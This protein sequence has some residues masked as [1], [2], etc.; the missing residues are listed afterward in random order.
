V[1]SDLTKDQERTRSLKNKSV[2]SPLKEFILKKR[3]ELSLSSAS[4]RAV[5]RKVSGAIAKRWVRKKLL[6]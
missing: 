4:G 5:E 3:G 6:N 1:A 2:L